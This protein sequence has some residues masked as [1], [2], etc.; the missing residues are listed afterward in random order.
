ML[1]LQQLNNIIDSKISLDMPHKI[2]NIINR[3][4]FIHTFITNFYNFNTELT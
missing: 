1:T 3:K 4:C 2:M